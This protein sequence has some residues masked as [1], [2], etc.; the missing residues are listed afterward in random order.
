LTVANG[1]TNIG[2]IELTDAGAGYGANLSITNGTLTN[3]TGAEIRAQAGAGGNRTF[4]FE[5][6]N[7]GTVRIAQA[8][9]LGRSGADHVNSGAIQITGGSL[10][11]DQTGTSPT[12]TN[13]GTIDAVGGNL[14]FTSGTATN[15]GTLNLGVS[16]TLLFQYSAV[17]NQQAG[18]INLAGG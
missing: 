8:T 18:A 5:L 6:L 16:R 13:N 12:F 7:Q 17:F 15:T 14:T 1:F 2:A 9:T 3:A 10:L 4:A 11:V